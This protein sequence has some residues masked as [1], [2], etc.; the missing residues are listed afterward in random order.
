MYLSGRTVKVIALWVLPAER[1]TIGG[2]ERG[3]YS[4]KG[5][6]PGK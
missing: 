3:R 6:L 2:P 1:G 5:Q 4:D